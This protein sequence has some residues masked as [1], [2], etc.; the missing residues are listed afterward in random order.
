MD[1][2][3]EALVRERTELNQQLRDYFATHGFSYRDYLDPSPDSWLA[4][5]HARIAEIDAV[6]SPE[7]TYYE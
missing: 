5:Y 7:L 2:D 4:Q 1:Q 6:L 3:R